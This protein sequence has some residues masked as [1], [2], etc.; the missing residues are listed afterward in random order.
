MVWVE[1]Q[2][3]TGG[4]HTAS[5]V[6]AALRKESE[7]PSRASPIPIAWEGGRPRRC[8]QPVGVPSG[9]APNRRAS[10]A[11]GFIEPPNLATCACPWFSSPNP[12]ST[13]LP[14]CVLGTAV[15]LPKLTGLG[16]NS[17][18]Y[19]CPYLLARVERRASTH[20]MLLPWRAAPGASRLRQKAFCGHG[21]EIVLL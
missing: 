16:D 5:I 7:R 6:L 10:F 18:A 13:S 2:R 14:G 1:M 15:P 3:L 20:L 12:T 8:G 11:L 21:P 9:A 17:A 4:Q 19:T